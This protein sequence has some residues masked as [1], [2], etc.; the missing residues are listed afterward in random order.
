MAG[1]LDKAST[2]FSMEISTEKTKIM[3][4]KSEEIQLDIE[5]SGQKL[6]SVKTFKYLKAIISDEGC[7]KKN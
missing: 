2:N 3:T 6:E 5:I 7:K 4:N 1:R